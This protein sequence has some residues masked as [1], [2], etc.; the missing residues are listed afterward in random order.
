MIKLYVDGACSGNPGPGGWG[1]V[2]VEGDDI[3]K[4]SGGIGFETTNNHMEMLAVLEGL[5]A[6][7]PFSEVTVYTDSR[8]VIGWLA[9]NFKC[10]VIHNRDM[11][12]MILSLCKEKKLE[13][14]YEKVK[15][16]SGD[17]YNDM[18]DQLAQEAVP[19]K[20]VSIEEEMP[21]DL[22]QSVKSRD[23][24]EQL[25]QWFENCGLGEL[26]TDMVAAIIRKWQPERK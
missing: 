1:V 18:A 4:L 20:T 14:T 13:V 2:V 6:V 17:K 8:L 16:H 23:V 10:K 3:Q 7:P 21:I 5:K 12:D 22:P 11:R 26:D 25:A 19:D 9:K 24:Q 15:G